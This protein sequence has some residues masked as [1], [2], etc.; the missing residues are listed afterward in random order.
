[1]P[2]D[3]IPSVARN[4]ERLFSSAAL[5][6]IQIRMKSIFSTSMST[7]QLLI[8]I[9]MLPK[10]YPKNLSLRKCRHYT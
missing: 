6:E 1:M 9:F 2:K 10:I 5:Q 7:G 8:S 3:I 4:T